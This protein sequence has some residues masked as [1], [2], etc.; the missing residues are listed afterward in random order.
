MKQILYYI[1]ELIPKKIML[2]NLRYIINNYY[3]ESNLAVFE[4]SLNMNYKSYI[5]NKIIEMT[6]EE[7]KNLLSK[8]II[9][10]FIL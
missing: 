1:W 2:D 5:Q 4:D 9:I 8:L 6:Y 7:I 3:K 10:N